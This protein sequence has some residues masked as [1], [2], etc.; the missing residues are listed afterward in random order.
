MKTNKKQVKIDKVIEEFENGYDIAKDLTPAVTVFGSARFTPDNKYYKDA[1]ELGYML[2]LEGYNVITGGGGGIMEAANRGAFECNKT[3]AVGFKITLPFEKHLNP[4][5]HIAMDFK[6]FYT[7]KYMLI[8]FSE[9][10]VV[11]PGGFGTLDELF[12]VLT[13]LQTAKLHHFK[14][15]LYD[16]KFWQ[17][18]T[19]FFFKSLLPNKVIS[20]EDLAR[21]RITDSLDYIVNSI[22]KD[23]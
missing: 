15:F 10:I 2:G 14:I 23:K 5:T 19:D 3:K 22:K 9:A 21:F 16:E 20:R 4:Y 7:R 17:P 1:L 18:M 6:H 13:L 12:E 11:F 8:N